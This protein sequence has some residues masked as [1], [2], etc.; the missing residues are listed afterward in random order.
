ML[1][2]AAS[3]GR[4]VHG[5]ASSSGGAARSEVYFEVTCAGCEN[6]WTIRDEDRDWHTTRNWCSVCDKKLIEKNGVFT[7]VAADTWVFQ[8]RASGPFQG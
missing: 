8:P 3:R 2:D 4:R 6:I 1:A 7:Q 5:Q